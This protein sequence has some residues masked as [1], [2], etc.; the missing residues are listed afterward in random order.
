MYPIR[1]EGRIFGRLGVY[2]YE[3]QMFAGQVI[4]NK[5]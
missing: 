4:L 3:I 2:L 1:N 5:G